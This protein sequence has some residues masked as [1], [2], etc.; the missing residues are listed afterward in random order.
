[1]DLRETDCEYL[2]YSA[3]WGALLMI[4]VIS[5]PIGLFLDRMKMYY[6]LKEHFWPCNQL[7]EELKVIYL[8]S[9]YDFY[10]FYCGVVHNDI[11][12]GLEFNLYDITLNV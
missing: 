2:N 1:V 9:D 3:A 12:I 5:E 4:M 7:I 11:N 10:Q 8:A 6:S